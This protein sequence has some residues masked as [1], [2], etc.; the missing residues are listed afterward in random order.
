MRK[1]NPSRAASSKSITKAVAN[2]PLRLAKETI[3]TL[4]AD[5]LTQ[6]ATGVALLYCPT[7][8]YPTQQDPGTIGG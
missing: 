2:R 8:S 1:K 7:P 3:R 4:S 5:E 6:A